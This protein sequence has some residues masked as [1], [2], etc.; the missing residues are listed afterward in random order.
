[1]NAIDVAVVAFGAFGIGTLLGTAIAREAMTRVIRLRIV[2]CQ[3][4]PRCAARNVRD[5]N[6]N[7]YYIA[8]GIVWIASLWIPSS[9]FDR[10]V[11]FMLVSVPVLWGFVFLTHWIKPAALLRW[12]KRP[13]GITGVLLLLAFLA[14]PM[15]VP[16]SS[17]YIFKEHRI[18]QSVRSK[19]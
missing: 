14:A 3:T 18:D 2:T 10:T 13:I 19:P 6:M 17:A 7:D 11:H 12:R 16:W 1:M 4:C 5:E 8:V 9:L 15:F